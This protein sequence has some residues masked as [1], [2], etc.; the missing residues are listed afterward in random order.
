MIRNHKSNS[1]IITETM[2]EYISINGNEFTFV[3]LFLL[4]TTLFKKLTIG[5]ISYLD[6]KTHPHSITI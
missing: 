5:E 6:N 2:T 3:V 4:G 1:Y